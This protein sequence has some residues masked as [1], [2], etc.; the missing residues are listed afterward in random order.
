MKPY[1]LVITGNLEQTQRYQTALSGI[2]YQVQSV[3]TGAHAQVQLSFT[4]PNLI[5]LDMKLPDIPGEVV[6][7]QIYAC[8]RLADTHLILLST[9]QIQL[10][11]QERPAPLRVIEHQIS[12]AELALL[13][14]E[15]G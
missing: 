5:V 4:T 12:A 13:A 3:N 15:M 1:A 8:Q 9:H 6:L 14:S 10:I 2:G 7:R 11:L